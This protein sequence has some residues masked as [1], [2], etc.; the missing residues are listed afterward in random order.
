MPELH[1]SEPNSDDEARDECA[2]VRRYYSELSL[3]R[4]RPS[5]A[6]AT[7]ST[8]RTRRT[9]LPALLSIPPTRDWTTPQGLA[10]GG[11]CGAQKAAG[12]RAATSAFALRHVSRPGTISTACPAPSLCSVLMSS[13]AA[14]LEPVQTA[15]AARSTRYSGGEPLSEVVESKNKPRG[16]PVA[17]ETRKQAKNMRPLE[18]Y[19]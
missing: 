12:V 17:V 11:S 9:T 18:N 6:P 8:I 4:R 7:R 14:R 13:R 15:P 5:T 10:T 2:Q 16:K 3:R 1:E 19:F